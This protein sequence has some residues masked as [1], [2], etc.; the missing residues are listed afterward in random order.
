[1]IYPQ[2]THFRAGMSVTGT[3]GVDGMPEWPASY[4]R[5]AASGFGDTGTTITGVPT[6]YAGTFFRVTC[7]AGAADAVAGVDEYDWYLSQRTDQTALQNLAI[8]NGAV[9][10][11]TY[12]GTA[13]ILHTAAAESA[14]GFT[15]TTVTP[16][17]IPL[18]FRHCY[19][20]VQRRSDSAIQWI[21]LLRAMTAGY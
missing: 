14:F 15:A 8:W 10:S 4:V 16:G 2:Y 6:P 7:N 12:S 1:M 5:L 11:N 13:R 19:L 9:G 20:Y 18:L 17:V 21:D 3:I